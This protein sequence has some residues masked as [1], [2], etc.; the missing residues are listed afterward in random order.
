M[1]G[2]DPSVNRLQEVAADMTGMEAALFV[3]S[4]TMGNLASVLAHCDQRGQEVHICFCQQDVRLAFG[5][6]VH[7]GQLTRFP[8]GDTMLGTIVSAT[9]CRSSLGTSRTSTTMRPAACLSS[10]ALP[11]TS[12]QTAQMGSSPW[13]SWQGLSG[14]CRKILTLDSSKPQVSSLATVQ[15]W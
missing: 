14:M 4:G 13:T 6:L 7:K 1:Y 12:F 15:P 9:K 11:S 2:E 3:S 10:E 5:Q 8:R